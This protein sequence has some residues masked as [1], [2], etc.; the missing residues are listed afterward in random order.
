MMSMCIKLGLRSPA[1]DSHQGPAS[2]INPGNTAIL[3]RQ[4]LGIVL[5]ALT[6]DCIRTTHRQKSRKNKRA[7]SPHGTRNIHPQIHTS[8]AMQ[9]AEPVGHEKPAVWKASERPDRRKRCRTDYVQ[10]PEKSLHAWTFA[11]ICFFRCFINYGVIRRLSTRKELG[12][13]MVVCNTHGQESRA[14][15]STAT[16]SVERMPNYDPWG[17]VVFLRAGASSRTGYRRKL[18]VQRRTSSSRMS[19]TEARCSSLVRRRTLVIA[20]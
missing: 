5:L 11:V 1:Q 8:Q 3:G 18:M 14:F 20:I 12:Q 13:G 16:L 15:Q 10:G 19:W 4:Q 6:L 2:G 9:E 7:G 17:L